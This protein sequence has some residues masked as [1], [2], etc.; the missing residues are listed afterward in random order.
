MVCAVST[1]ATTSKEFVTTGAAAK[2]VLPGWLALMVQ[3]PTATSVSVVPLTVQTPGVVEA[4]DTVRPDDAVAIRAGAGLPR[5]WLPG[6]VKVMVCGVSGAVATLKEFDTVGAA[7]KLALPAWL[8][9]TV[10]VPT[11]TKLSVLPLTVHTPKVVDAKDTGKPELAVATSGAG[12]VPSVWPPGDVKVMVCEPGATVKDRET[13]VA[14]A[15]VASPAWLAVIEQVPAPTSVAAVPLTVHTPSVVDANDTGRPDE[16]VAVSATGPAPKVWFAGVAK[17]M[18]CGVRATSK[19]FETF[20]AAARV[21]SPA[22]LATTVQVPAA[23]SDKVVPLTVHTAGVVEAN[24]TVK[25]EVE[26]A[27]SG[28]GG[29]PRTWLP[30][31]AKV[32]VCGISAA[33]TVKVWVTPWAA[34]KFWLPDWLAVMLQEPVASSVNAV[35]STAHT[36]GVFEA[37]DTG[38]PEVAVAISAD[39]GLPSVWLPGEMNEI[40]CVPGVTVMEFE[41]GTAGLKFALPAWLALTTQVPVATSVKAVPLTVQTLVVVEAN[42]TVRLDVDVATSGAGWTPKTWLPGELNVIVC[43][44]GGGACDPGGASA[45]P[46][47]QATSISSDVST[48]AAREVRW[49]DRVIT[50]VSGGF[51]TGAVS[52]HRPRHVAASRTKDPAGDVVADPATLKALSFDDIACH[53]GWQVQANSGLHAVRKASAKQRQ[54]PSRRRKSGCWRRLWGRQRKDCCGPGA[55]RPRRRPSRSEA[56][57]RCRSVSPQPPVTRG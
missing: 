13:G 8:A 11:A 6:D 5:V 33:A 42:A 45:S 49:L 19:E 41:T 4:K 47:P 57:I 20:G 56:A 35:P 29:V 9:A 55:H 14:G 18:V 15:R 53:Q 32:M 1:A 2:V 26:V 46:P 51:C 12:G 39:V 22:W 36:A 40:V 16:A 44:A 21:A 54:N 31:D 43:A 10:Q 7:A 3:V 24:A 48:Q 23:A 17:V 52:H 34:A 37:N 28:A 25:P 50:S 27:T 38:R 30:G